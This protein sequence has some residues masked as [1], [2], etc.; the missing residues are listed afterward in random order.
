MV[1]L[2]NI[3]DL[4]TLPAFFVQEY[5][6]D[7]RVDRMEGTKEYPM[8]VMGWVLEQSGNN[9]IILHEREQEKHPLG[10][11]TPKYLTRIFKCTVFNVY[12]NKYFRK[13]G[14]FEPKVE[15]RDEKFVYLKMTILPDNT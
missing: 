8:Y 15:T 11:I 3:L 12:T 1:D 2:I 14:I 13:V 7:S 6:E 5:F 9:L 4:Y 10:I